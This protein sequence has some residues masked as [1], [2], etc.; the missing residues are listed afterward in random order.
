MSL[1][2]GDVIKVLEN[3]VCPLGAHPIVVLFIEGDTAF[4]SNITDIENEDFVP[5]VLELKDDPRI[6]TIK[7]T[8]RFQSI[9]EWSVTTVDRAIENAKLKNFGQLAVAAFNKIITASQLPDTVIKPKYRTL[10][11]PA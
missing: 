2:R 6:I 3:G 7:S 10:L 5:C 4:I 8:F 9:S 11:K 1:K